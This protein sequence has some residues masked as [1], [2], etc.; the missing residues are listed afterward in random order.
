MNTKASNRHNTQHMHLTPC[1]CVRKRRQ[2]AGEKSLPKAS[3]I[4]AVY[5]DL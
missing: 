1:P 3:S 2:G 4:S 5:R